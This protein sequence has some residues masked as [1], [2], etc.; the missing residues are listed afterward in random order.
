MKIFVTGATESGSTTFVP[1][2][3]CRSYLPER[4]LGDRTPASPRLPR[5]DH[6]PDAI[7]IAPYHLNPA[8]SPYSR[9][10]QMRY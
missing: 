10:Q 7:R 3:Y 8:H 5:F 2:L 1:S 6:S 4:P 9:E